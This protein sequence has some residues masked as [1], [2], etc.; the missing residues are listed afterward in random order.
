MA[1]VLG[2]VPNPGS[3]VL[4]D[5][6]DWVCS[7]WEEG[8]SWEEGTEVWV[9]I[10]DS[11]FD[12]VV[13]ESEARASF[14]VQSTDVDPIADGTKFTVYMRKPTTPTTEYAWFIGTVK[15]RDGATA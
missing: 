4:S 3:I 14:L 9:V 5:G 2:Y 7:L 15:R 11:T 13:T 8:V 10:G 12:A 1:T 6:A